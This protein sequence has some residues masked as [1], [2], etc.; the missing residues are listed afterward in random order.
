MKYH[1]LAI[2]RNVVFIV[3]HS[4]TLNI[5]TTL[6][7]HTFLTLIGTSLFTPGMF[8]YVNPSLVGLGSIE[9]AASLSYKLNLGGYHLIGKVST[10]ITPGGFET[11]IDGT[12]TSQGVR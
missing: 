4:I 2:H 9:D 10:T 6:F 8:Y 5:F 12:Q 3:A 1:T 11:V 7:C